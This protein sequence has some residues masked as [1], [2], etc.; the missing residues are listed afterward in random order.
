MLLIV[1]VISLVGT[2]IGPIE[3][4]LS[5]HFIV[6]PFP[7]VDTAIAPVVLTVTL[8]IIVNKGAVEC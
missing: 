1:L 2:T 5:F 3:V 6:L 8:N 7:L 4:A